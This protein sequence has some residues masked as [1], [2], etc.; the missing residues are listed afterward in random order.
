MGSKYSGTNLQGKGDIRNCSCYRVAKLPVH[1][2]KVMKRVLENR[3]W[4]IV[5]VDEMQFDIKP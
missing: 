4:R 2:M 5:T 3:V 1:G